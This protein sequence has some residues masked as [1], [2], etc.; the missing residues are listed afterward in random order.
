LAARPRLILLDECLSGLNSV[1]IQQGIS[2]VR[3]LRDRGIAILIIE[4][5]MRVISELADRVIVLDRGE[6]IADGPAASVL[7]DQRALDVYFGSASVGLSSS[8]TEQRIRPSTS[9]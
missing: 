2:L 9:H 6:K 8:M 4:H 1:E 5:L 3:A 7:T